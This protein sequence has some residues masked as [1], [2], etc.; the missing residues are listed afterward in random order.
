MSPIKEAIEALENFVNDIVPTHPNDPL[1]VKGRAALAALRSMPAEPVAWW[2]QKHNCFGQL[3]W[4]IAFSAP[5]DATQ[6][7]PLFATPP[8]APVLSDAWISVTD[9]TPL[10]EEETV[11]VADKF[12]NVGFGE[13]IDNV[14]DCSVG[15]IDGDCA[16]YITHW[17]PLPPPPIE[18]AIGR[19][20]RGV[21]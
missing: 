7:V 20:S 17:M 1:W 18:Q 12:G 6:V 21:K 3:V 10:D 19:A 14:W 15:V 16:G 13:F 9:R 11:L 8:P 4:D 5:R 2:F